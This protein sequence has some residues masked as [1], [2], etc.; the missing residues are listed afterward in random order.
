MKTLN[1]IFKEAGEA[2]IS[3]SKHK[4]LNE[5]SE[6]KILNNCSADAI[7]GEIG[8]TAR[9]IYIQEHKSNPRPTPLEKDKLRKMLN[10][11]VYWT[12]EKGNW[13]ENPIADKALIWVYESY[14][15]PM[16]CAN[17]E[18]LI[19]S[20]GQDDLF[21]IIDELKKGGE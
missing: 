18:D 2:I 9:T 21:R 6:F 5:S 19:N 20:I 7:L 1:E 10:T 4:L 3:L 15:K 8:T 12:K 11:K 17:F 14:S 13:I 16:K